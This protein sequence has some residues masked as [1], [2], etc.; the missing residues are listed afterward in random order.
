M[1][2]RETQYKVGAATCQDV[3]LAIAALADAETDL[4]N[5]EANCFAARSRLADSV[6]A[7]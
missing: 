6:G 4:A 3:A 1:S 7:E 2:V 5:A